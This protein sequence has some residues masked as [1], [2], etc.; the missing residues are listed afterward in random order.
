M[1]DESSSD[2]HSLKRLLLG[3]QL[4]PALPCR[5]S[6]FPGSFRGNMTPGSHSRAGPSPLATRSLP[7]LVSLGSR[8]VKASPVYLASAAAEIQNSLEKEEG[9]DDL[10]REEYIF[11]LIV[12]VALVVIGGIFVRRPSP[13]STPCSWNSLERD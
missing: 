8:L 6:P 12:S 11:K 10:T 7:L 4:P 9:P 1:T 5:F 3:P 2:V 13:R